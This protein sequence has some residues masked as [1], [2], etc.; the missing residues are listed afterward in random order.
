MPKSYADCGI[1]PA[2]TA[3][4][5]AWIVIGEARGAGGAAILPLA[6]LGAAAV[7]TVLLLPA[8]YEEAKLRM[9]NVDRIAQ[10]EDHAAG[11][12]Q[13][14]QE[15]RGA[16]AVVH[17]LEAPALA[18]ELARLVAVVVEVERAQRVA[19]ARRETARLQVRDPGVQALLLEVLPLA[20]LVRLPA[21]RR[22][23]V[24]HLGEDVAEAHV[25]APDEQVR[26]RG[27]ESLE[28]R[29]GMASST[30][31]RMCGCDGEARTGC[32]ISCAGRT[33]AGLAPGSRRD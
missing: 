30:A 33:F 14:E 32:E 24:D 21:P 17:F 13:V 28:E 1:V 8:A 2:P 29:A 23:A 7:F 25:L 22:F 4:G 16:R 27:Q 6:R 11:R 19:Q 31:P 12:E 10:H 18:A 9:T 3:P 5:R 20:D 15:A 26:R